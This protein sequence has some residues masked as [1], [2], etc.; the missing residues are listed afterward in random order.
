MSYEQQR[1]IASRGGRAAHTKGTAH[2]WSREEA[3]AAGRKGG[4]HRG[5]HHGA[6]MTGNTQALMVISSPVATLAPRVES[7]L[8]QP[9][10]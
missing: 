6:A 4:E 7:F 1:R 3:I 8:H 2:E 5:N 10:R 9:L